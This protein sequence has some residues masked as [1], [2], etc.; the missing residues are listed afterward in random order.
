MSDSPAEPPGFPELLGR[1]R[2]GE[3]EALEEVIRR[4]EPRLRAS[5]DRLLGRKLRESVRSS[6]VLQNSYLAMLDALPRF[7]GSTLEAFVAWLTQIIAHDIRHQHRWFTAKRRRAPSQTSERNALARILLESPPT[8]STEIMRLEHAE[9][10][11]VALDRLESDHAAI[12]RL[13]MFEN[14]PYR[15]VAQRLQRSEGACRMLLMRARAALA[16]E[17]DRLSDG[18]LPESAS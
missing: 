8:P 7:Q 15:E 1:A 4:T 5:V 3:R 6:D 11:R 17:L 9:L 18:T 13:V 16:I 10:V 14:L 2:R 12:I